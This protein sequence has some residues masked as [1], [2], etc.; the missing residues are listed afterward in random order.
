VLTWDRPA[1][2]TLDIVV[3]AADIDELGHTNNAVYVRWLERCA[4][5]HSEALGLDLASYRQLDRAMV[6]LR[7]E[8]DYLAAAY[9]GDPL[10]V[11]TWIVQSDNRLRLTRKFQICRVSDRQTLLRA[12]STFVCIA[13]TSG[14][15]KRMPAAFVEH[16]GGAT[17]EPIVTLS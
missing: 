1:P 13:L 4:W 9:L 8:I 15:P 2:H 11:A 5:Q 6:V 16:Y 3:G 14:R 10:Q 17:A 12:Q 7:H